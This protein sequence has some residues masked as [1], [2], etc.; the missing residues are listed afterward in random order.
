MTEEEHINGLKFRLKICDRILSGTNMVL[1]YAK[2]E[3]IFIWR[4]K[5]NLIDDLNTKSIEKFDKMKSLALG[6]KN[7]NERKVAF[8]KSIKLMETILGLEIYD[9][10]SER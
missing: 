5:N 9:K 2:L 6:N 4:Y 8:V 3:D 1:A 7:L 10:A